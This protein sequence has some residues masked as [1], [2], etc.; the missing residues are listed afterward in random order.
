MQK[1]TQVNTKGSSCYKNFPTSI[2]PIKSYPSHAIVLR[3]GYS[4]QAAYDPSWNNISATIIL[5]TSNK[6]DRQCSTHEYI[7]TLILLPWTLLYLQKALYSKGRKRTQSAKKFHFLAKPPIHQ[8]LAES[9][10]SIERRLRAPTNEASTV[11]IA[12]EPANASFGRF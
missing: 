7:F 12:A 11:G 2:Q 10:P 6:G 4:Y 8:H 3:Q 5:L 1:Q 9:R